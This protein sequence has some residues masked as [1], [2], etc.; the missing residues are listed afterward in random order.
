MPVL[1]ISYTTTNEGHA[2]KHETEWVSPTG[3]TDERSVESFTFRHPN[4]IITG[5]SDIT[6]D[7]ER[8]KGAS[9]EQA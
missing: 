9:P 3:W 4:A 1:L 7:L 5:V 8:E 6:P 2:I